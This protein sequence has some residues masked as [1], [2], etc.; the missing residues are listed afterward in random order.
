MSHCS[1]R[2]SLESQTKT[3]NYE[4]SS[5]IGKGAY[6]TVY[7]GRD[8]KIQDRYV[9][10]KEITI[11]AT[12]EEGI[13]SSSIREIGLLKQLEKF[14]HPNVVKL[15][16][17]FFGARTYNEI[18]LNLVFEHF[19]QD[20]SQYI[21]KAPSGLDGDTIRMLT[22][23]ILSGIDFLHSQRIFHR[24]LKPQNILI[25][26]SGLVKI[27]DFGLAKVFSYQ[28]ALTSVVV[29]LFYR[30][31]EVLLMESYGTAV[32]IWS[33]GCIFAELHTRR[34]LFKGV[35]E[36]DQLARILECIGVPDEADW[37]TSISLPR[38]SFRQDPKKS[39]ELLVP[40][41]DEVAL[42]MLKKMLIFQQSQRITALQALG[43]PYFDGFQL[44]SEIA[45]S[46]LTPSSSAKSP[47][48][49]QSSEPP[50]SQSS[51][52]S[53]GINSPKASFDEATE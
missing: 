46:S 51:S 52:F 38:M 4:V 28:M 11:S 23:Q 37:P 42:G 10:L 50:S 1:P 34:P 22:Y 32:D 17:V 7:K 18:K 14:D 13:P 27:A 53:S 21:L 16:D 6:A 20:L 45:A 48:L 35:S 24:D 31:P 5:T 9:A 43:D 26:D 25:S 12:S 8:K 3:L 30:A 33:C 29:T 39:L 44:P 19:N 41:A 47:S 36:V 2:T 49:S 40:Q 15:L